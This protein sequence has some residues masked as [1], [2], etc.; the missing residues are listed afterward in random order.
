MVGHARLARAFQWHRRCGDLTA[1]SCITLSFSFARFRFCRNL[2][3]SFDCL[4][5]DTSLSCLTP[6]FPCFLVAHCCPIISLIRQN[7]TK[8]YRLYERRAQHVRKT[9][10]PDSVFKPYGHAS[11]AEPPE[12]TCYQSIQRLQDNQSIKLLRAGLI[13]WLVMDWMFV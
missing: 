3:R 1:S 13:D 9:T 8:E 7:L 5:P 10:D 2:W 6:L 12:Q 11:P 4:S